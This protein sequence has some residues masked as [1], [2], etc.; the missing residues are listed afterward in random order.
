MKIRCL[1]TALIFITV[2]P[3]VAVP[4]WASDTKDERPP[5]LTEL[6]LEQL[7]D[8]EVPTIYGA[9]KFEQKVTDAPAS[10]SVITADEIQKY[11]HRTLAD[12]L[13]SV[14]GLYV[15]YDRNYHFLG[16]RGFNRPGDYNSRVLLLLD[17]H[18]I[19]DNIYDTATVGTEFPLD[20]DLIDRIEIIRGPSSSLYGTSAFFGVI[21][22][23]SRQG[24][25]MK[26]AEVA[27]SVGSEDSYNGRLSYGNKYPSGLELLI[28]GSVYN[29]DGE[30]EL[31]YGEFD[32]PAT[33]NGIADHA[34]DDK[35][36]SFFSK[37]TFRDLT[38]TGAYISREKGIPT[39]SFDTVF[40][41]NRN[42]TTDAHGYV[43]LKY[44]HKLENQAE[45]TAR[46]F[47]DDYEYRGDYIYDGAN[48]GDPLVVNKDSSDGQ[49]AGGEL[50]FTGRFQGKHVFT[51]G[52][53]ER[54]NLR[55]DQRTYDESPFLS[56][57]D[58]KRTS[59]TYALYIQ[60]EYHILPNLI[61]NVGLRYDYYD[62][63]GGTTNPRLDLIYK[64]WDKTIL[65]LLYGDAFRAPNVYEL[66]Y[67]DNGVTARPNPDLKPEKIG[68]Y[69][70]V[71]E[72]YLGEHL[73]TSLS[74]F[75][76]QIDDLITQ[77]TDTDGLLIYRNMEKVEAKGVE[78][79]VEGKW[80]E[81][82]Q[83][84]V[85]YILQ[86]AKNKDTGD[87]L[88]NSPRHLAKLNLAAPLIRKNVL[89]GA[90]LQYTSSRKTL[91]GE[92]EGGFVTANLTLFSQNLLKGLEVSA[93]L[94]NL[95]DR[96]YGDPG[97]GE[98]LQNIIGQDGRTFRVKF[99]YRF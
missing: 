82:L 7:M 45:L 75:Y 97:A 29:S 98:H 41:D 31:Y 32:A 46:V 16:V 94:Y 59:N 76:Y 34:D 11:G 62:T 47:Y 57:L 51:A 4:V 21:N 70:L 60:D 64:P 54:Y 19:N 18:R 73:R 53:E 20:V 93:S 39:G 36:H 86:E 74:G 88:T 33:N 81:G 52:A 77:Q 78:M 5:S 87:L 49:W 35:S 15:T 83:G 91:A 22:V 2:Y 71:Y 12:I 50:M 96:K 56:K 28:S 61:F 1:L 58:D 25:D 48:P 99:V 65:K 69:E 37:F 38:L 9:C 14:H 30:R 3:L 79:E 72:Q 67:E 40:N 95:L 26:S 66:Y 23:I 68:T 89:A 85:S 90:E 44:A 10:V 43:D 42:R 27:G 55:Q 6:S 63:F 80:A 92:N 24:K 84:R 17:G 13:R 8:I